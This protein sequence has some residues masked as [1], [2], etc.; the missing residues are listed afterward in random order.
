MF[1]VDLFSWMHVCVVLYHV[2]RTRC[3]RE[4]ACECTS[5]LISCDGIEDHLILWP[6]GELIHIYVF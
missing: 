6:E 4:H 3:E 5:I 2:D 1:I